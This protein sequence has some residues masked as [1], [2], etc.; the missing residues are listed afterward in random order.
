MPDYV[1]LA[2]AL[3]QAFPEV[4]AQRLARA[5]AFRAGVDAALQVMGEQ[6]LV[7]EVVAAGPLRGALNPYG[8]VIVRVRQVPELVAE[9]AR[10]REDQAEAARWRQVDRAAKRG[11]TLRALVERGDLTRDEALE[12]V[13]ADFRDDTD[14]LALARAAVTGGKP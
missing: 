8:V 5:R 3:A 10:L 14:L 9:R 12:Q 6:D 7:A 2:I 4:D 11:E 13:G 1:G